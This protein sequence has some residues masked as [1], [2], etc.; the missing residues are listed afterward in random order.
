MRLEQIL[1]TEFLSLK[2]KHRETL[3]QYPDFIDMVRQH[4]PLGNDSTQRKERRI[5]LHDIAETLQSYTES[6]EYETIVSNRQEQTNGEMLDSWMEY[7]ALNEALM[8]YVNDPQEYLN[9]SHIK[10]Q[11]GMTE[12]ARLRYEKNFTLNNFYKKI[13]QKVFEINP[14]GAVETAPIY[15]KHMTA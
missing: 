7:T 15:G 12:T 3:E 1:G 8:E 5:I 2:L 10:E 9:D 4:F 13:M 6:A 11:K 14:E